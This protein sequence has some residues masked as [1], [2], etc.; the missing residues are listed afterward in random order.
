MVA[1]GQILVPCIQLLLEKLKTRGYKIP[2]CSVELA[3]RKPGPRA[4]VGGNDGQAP[5]RYLRPDPMLHS[6]VEQHKWPRETQQKYRILL[7]TVTMGN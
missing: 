2:K 5:V 7:D 3:E 4:V 6:K 1:C